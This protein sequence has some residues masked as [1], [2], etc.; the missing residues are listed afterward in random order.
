M[1]NYQHMQAQAFDINRQAPDVDE[2]PLYPLIAGSYQQMAEQAFDLNGDLITPA[3]T[4]SYSEYA[5]HY[6]S[7]QSAY[8]ALPADV[9][10][11][12]ISDDYPAAPFLGAPGAPQLPFVSPVPSFDD[13][14]ANH[15]GGFSWAEQ[16]RPVPEQYAP[17]SEQ[18]P[19]LPGQYPLLPA[20]YPPL[21]TYP[22]T[23]TP[24]APSPPSSPS[25]SDLALSDSSPSP[26]PSPSPSD[27]ALSDYTPTPA[28]PSW[29]QTAAHHHLAPLTKYALVTR[30]AAEERAPP[31]R[32]RYYL[33][34][35]K[36]PLLLS[37]LQPEPERPAQKRSAAKRSVV[38]PRDDTPRPARPVQKK[39]KRSVAGEETPQRR[40]GPALRK[41]VRWVRKAVA[42]VVRKAAAPRKV[43]K[44]AA[45]PACRCRAD[46]PVVGRP[47]D[48]VD[49]VDADESEFDSG[50]EVGEPDSEYEEA[51]P[52]PRR[53]R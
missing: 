48:D 2:Y 52:A 3:D 42:P 49:V 33:P 46:A 12:S 14:D 51:A 15:D 38:V 35:D 20:Q 22:F 34:A 1:A 11:S 23:F 21:P 6:A 26:P 39:R 9:P 18:Y 5:S 41:A 19:P 17:M 43:V 31:F 13:D 29:T 32:P 36:C 8:P 27:L 28:S 47:D 50:S 53:R 4:Y 30:Y 16:Y 7:H 25:P 37:P 44:A 45:A 24:P 40:P 10:F